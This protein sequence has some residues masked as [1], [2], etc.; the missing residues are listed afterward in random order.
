MTQDP[1]NPGPGG[2]PGGDGPRPLHLYQEVEPREQDR[3]HIRFAGVFQDK[4]VLWDVVILTLERCARGAPGHHRPWRSFID[5]S[6]PRGGVVAVTVGLPVGRTDEPT[7]RKTIKMIRQYRA[8][9]AGHHEYGG[10]VEFDGGHTE[11]S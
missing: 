6:G 1:A 8:L 7:I 4:P 3:A 9:A 5:V 2:R 10:Y 11:T